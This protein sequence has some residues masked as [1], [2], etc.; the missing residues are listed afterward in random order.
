MKIPSRVAVSVGLAFASP[1]W[2][3]APCCRVA[4]KV[5]DTIKIGGAAFERPLGA[6]GQNLLNGVNLA[7]KN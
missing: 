1:P 4:A 5:P 3:L 7:V 2:W 6:L